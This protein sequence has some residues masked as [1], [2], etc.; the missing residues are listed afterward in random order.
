MSSLAGNVY[1]NFAIAS[2]DADAAA[3]AFRRQRGFNNTAVRNG[4]GDY[5]LT[6]QEACDFA[7]EAIVKTGILAATAG[8]I[9]VEA[10]STTVLRVRSLDSA[11]MAADRDFWIEVTKIGPN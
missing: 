5:S 4:A 9:G 1:G 2:Y 7:N 3:P 8:M 10:V 6:T 11:A